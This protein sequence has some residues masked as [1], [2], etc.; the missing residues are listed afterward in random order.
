M[1]E[2]SD[3]T[4]PTN[5]P[6]KRR[7][8]RT[9]ADAAA[10]PSP[11]QQDDKTSAPIA[12]NSARSSLWQRWSQR[13][14]AFGLSAA[15]RAYLFVGSIAA[16]LA[17]LIYGEYVIREFKISADN[18]VHFHANLLAYAYSPD[19]TPELFSLI[20]NEVL[21]NRRVDFPQIHTDHKGNIQF[22]G[23]KGL[24]DPQDRSAAAERELR[25]TMRRMDAANAPIPFPISEGSNG[26][27]H[28]DGR[29]LIITD[30][31]KDI[32][33]WRGPDLPAEGDTSVAV[34]PALQ[35]AL[36]RIKTDSLS[37]SHPFTIPGQS[38]S[39]LYYDQMNFVISDSTGVPISWSGTAL[40]PLSDTSTA[41][42]K[43]VVNAMLQMAEEN[44]P[45]IFH[46]APDSRKIHYGDSDL[47][48]RM[49]WAMYVQIGVL[50]LF[51]LIGYVGFRNIRRSE[52]R[53]IWVGMA[54]ET[55]H[56]LG[57]PLSSLAGWLEL[58]K[59]D[60]QNA[61]TA[62]DA[63]ALE[64]I[65]QKIAEMQKDMRHLNQ[66][67]SR[68]SQIGSVPELKPENIEAVLAETITYF[69]SRSPQFGRH[70][71]TMESQ[72][73]AP[74]PANAELLSWVFENLFKNAIDAF[75]SKEGAIHV[76]LGPLP[77]RQAVHITFQDTGRGIN[78]EHVNQV[79]EPGFSTKKRGW[80]LGLAFVKRIIE[81]YHDGHIAVSQSVPGEGTT[82][83]IIL[84]IE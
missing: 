70:E 11:P 45:Y 25:E 74:V 58:V 32:V 62:T 27:L 28:Y 19:A 2:H 20:F 76:H 21:I 78:P 50:I 6:L 60:I 1:D 72:A 14:A 24:P 56:Q 46:I 4:S 30:V 29:N 7:R 81:E 33:G 73:I 84:P 34:I 16:I 75:E 23:G 41:T 61:S 51:M 82:F 3:P 66:I 68:F 40:P 69:K 9:T 53:S 26:V 71:I 83:E 52:Q 8:R 79:F 38:F 35:T 77:D 37:V 43:R 54:K 22:W 55:A 44:D 42:K 80:G 5:T 64:R 39:Y 47:V 31:A 10:H 65:D 15:F 57:T 67:A 36:A 48:H 13:L 18:Q 49:S 17:F 63:N 59:R 12:T